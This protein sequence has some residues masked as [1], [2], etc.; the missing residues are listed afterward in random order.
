MSRKTIRTCAVLSSVLLLVY[1]VYISFDEG[2]NLWLSDL[3]ENL[4][5]GD[6]FNAYT[7]FYFLYVGFFSRDIVLG[8]VLLIPSIVL[9]AMSKHEQSR[10][11]K[12]STVA[13][14]VLSSVWLG[15]SL[16]QWGVN[17]VIS[18]NEFKQMIESGPPT[19]TVIPYDETLQVGEE[20]VVQFDYS[21][22]PAYMQIQLLLGKAV[23]VIL[24]AIAIYFLIS[25]IVKLLGGKDGRLLAKATMIQPAVGVMTLV[26]TLLNTI[27]NMIY[28]NDFEASSKFMVLSF[29]HTRIY[30]DNM[31]NDLLPLVFA[32]LIL[33]IGLIG[34]K[35][36][37]RVPL[38]GG[39]EE[40]DSVVD[41]TY[42][43]MDDKE[44]TE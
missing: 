16:L 2:L 25:F 6:E 37:E 18:I 7:M 31:I 41:V 1:F 33:I 26:S 23:S 15:V 8:L 28:Q 34:K 17:T 4:I 44:E 40:M 29:S 42:D 20:Y 3:L 14:V 30:L 43:D 5:L 21:S 24:M 12:R 10:I 22:L 13:A 32:L 38:P 11:G 39:Y 36:H 27:S 19:I 35:Q 9:L